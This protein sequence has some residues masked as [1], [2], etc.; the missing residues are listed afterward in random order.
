MEYKSDKSCILVGT[1]DAI[2]IHAMENGQVLR[3]CELHSD[4]KDIWYKDTVGAVLECG[5]L[6][7]IDLSDPVYTVTEVFNINI[8][9]VKRIERSFLGRSMTVILDDEQN[10]TVFTEGWGDDSFVQI[11]HDA[12]VSVLGAEA[13]GNL[14][15]VIL[16][17]RESNGYELSLIDT[18]RMT[19]R[20]R[21]KL[22]EELF[23][24]VYTD[25]FINF[26]EDGSGIRLFIYGLPREEM[27]EYH[28]SMENGTEERISIT[29]TEGLL[30]G[31]LNCMTIKG[32]PA[33]L[34][35][36]TEKPEFGYKII[37]LEEGCFAEHKLM[38]PAE[39]YEILS[40]YSSFGDGRYQVLAARREGYR[41]VLLYD[42][43]E[44]S[45]KVLE[46]VSHRM[47]DEILDLRVY[48]SDEKIIVCEADSRSCWIF[49]PSAGKAVIN[50]DFQ[51]STVASVDIHDN[52]VFVFGFDGYLREYD[53]KKGKLKNSIRLTK[54]FD[55]MDQG[56]WYYDEESILF[57]F[58]H[59]SGRK[60][61]VLDLKELEPTDEIDS[62]VEYIPETH[63]ILVN[64]TEVAFEGFIKHTLDELIEMG[65][66]QL[67]ES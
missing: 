19:E 16:Q 8:E 55:V 47:E 15:A 51:E 40:A 46:E 9:K 41:D 42:L 65:Y 23:S 61:F 31:S 62:F 43:Q 21:K 59:D 3:R 25:I 44:D 49:D 34:V 57:C 11:G 6:A 10:L 30:T 33:Y 39:D 66:E 24:G 22:P 26:T 12:A 28:Y 7:R 56:E 67:G 27:V 13:C 18:D 48:H 37:R 38:L 14:A 4:V 20:W 52:R 35:F 36:D 17:D 5:E 29:G 53:L 32:Y 64:D 60:G 1:S 63:T 50:L 45:C 54:S 58:S 2:S